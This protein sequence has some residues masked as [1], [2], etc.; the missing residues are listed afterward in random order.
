MRNALCLCWCLL[1]L[2]RSDFH[3]FGTDIFP[4][5]YGQS[6]IIFLHF[7]QKLEN[8]WSEKNINIIQLAEY[9]V[10]EKKREGLSALYLTIIYH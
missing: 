10:L 3:L 7:L 6:C 4:T 5:S 2:L 9:S 8:I 1:V